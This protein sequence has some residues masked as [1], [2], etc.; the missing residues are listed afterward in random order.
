[1]QRLQLRNPKIQACVA[2]ATTVFLLYAIS[3]ITAQQYDV[4]VLSPSTPRRALALN[5]RN[6]FVIHSGPGE[7][8]IGRLYRAS[9]GAIVR[10]PPGAPPP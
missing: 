9:A 1:M 5:D 10:R 4:S 7:P 3:L 2:G 8:L 6:E